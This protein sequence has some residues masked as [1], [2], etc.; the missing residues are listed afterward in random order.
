M[1]RTSVFFLGE[2]T[3][4]YKKNKELTSDTQM[5]D[6]SLEEEKS[7]RKKRLL[8]LF[9]RIAVRVV[10]LLKEAFKNQLPAGEEGGPPQS[11][12]VRE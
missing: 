2:K 10:H 8:E 4:T 6:E 1:H 11:H 7:K 5:L 9:E 3:W 12:N